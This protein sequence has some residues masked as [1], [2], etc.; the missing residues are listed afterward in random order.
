MKGKSITR[1][2]VVVAFKPKKIMRW[3]EILECSPTQDV[4]HQKGF[5]DYIFGSG[6]PEPSLATVTETFSQVLLCILGVLYGCDAWMNHLLKADVHYVLMSGHPYV[7][8]WKIWIKPRYPQAFQTMH[9]TYVCM[10]HMTYVKSV[11]LNDISIIF[12]C[13]LPNFQSPTLFWVQHSL[14][15]RLHWS[16]PTALVTRGDLFLFRTGPRR[17][18]VFH[19]ATRSFGRQRALRR[20]GG[21]CFR[22]FFSTQQKRFLVSG[23][24]GKMV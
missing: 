10:I 19:W 18:S 22:C 24:T 16:F 4:S 20:L 3:D 13:F 14:H 17:A 6:I 5:D 2:D 21:R 1:P 23:H 8:K 11:H 9:D 7:F 15:L 12:F